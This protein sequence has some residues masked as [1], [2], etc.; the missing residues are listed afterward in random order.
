MKFKTCNH[1]NNTHITFKTINAYKFYGQTNVELHH[2][3]CRKICYILLHHWQHVPCW[4]KYHEIL[5]TK[6]L[7][8]WSHFY[9]IFRSFFRCIHSIMDTKMYLRK[10]DVHLSHLEKFIT[11]MHGSFNGWIFLTIQILMWHMRGIIR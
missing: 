11:W 8:I 10:C 9:I 3:D 2:V 4:F 7:N 5:Y 1:K 6:N